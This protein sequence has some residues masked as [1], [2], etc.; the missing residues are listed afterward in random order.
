[1]VLAAQVSLG[2][3]KALV[4]V[5]LQHLVPH[6][7]EAVEAEPGTEL[8]VPVA[9]LVEVVEPG[10]LVE[11]AEQVLAAKEIMAAP[12]QV[13]DQQPRRRVVVVVAPAE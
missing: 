5:I 12:Q 6:Q 11:V 8:Q 3:F 13:M 4:V 1:L 10:V 9:A 7:P 2:Y